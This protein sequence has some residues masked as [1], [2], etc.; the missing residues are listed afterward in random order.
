MSASGLPKLIGASRSSRLSE[1]ISPLIDRSIKTAEAA[2]LL[3]YSSAALRKW[4]LE[5]KGPRFIRHMRSVRY[6]VSDLRDWEEKHAIK[7]AKGE[8]E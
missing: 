8:G 5:G 7:P 1:E 6:K 3:G 4:R 2:R